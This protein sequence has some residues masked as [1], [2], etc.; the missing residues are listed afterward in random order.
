MSIEVNQGQGSINNNTNYAAEYEF[1]DFQNIVVGKLATRLKWLGYAV[2]VFMATQALL[3]IAV[4]SHNPG[5]LLE[6]MITSIFTG[7]FAAL[8]LSASRSF[9]KIT[10]T[11]GEDMTHLIDAL[12]KLSS[13]YAAQSVL[14]FIGAGFVGLVAL[15]VLVAR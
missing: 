2:V 14:V 11:Q 13:V 8:M 15:V 4:V 3:A 12:G 5:K 1:D 10:K 7:C 6:V 9:S